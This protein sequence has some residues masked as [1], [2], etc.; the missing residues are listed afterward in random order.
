MGKDG[1]WKRTRARARGCIQEPEDMV[2]QREERMGKEE[3]D[4]CMGRAGFAMG[5]TLW[6]TVLFRKEKGKDRE[7]FGCWRCTGATGLEK[8]SGIKGKFND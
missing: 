7:V 2:P 1:L 6:L 8:V 4:Q 5:T 3:R